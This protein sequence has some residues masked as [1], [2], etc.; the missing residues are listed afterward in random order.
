MQETIQNTG[1]DVEIHT[2]ES[3]EEGIK[4]SHGLK[5]NDVVVLDTLLSGI[6]GFEACKRIKAINE[7]IKVI[8]C[9]G[10]VDAVDATR[11]RAAGADDYCVKTENYGLLI[12]AVKQLT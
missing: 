9:T 5:P 1:W 10:V 4:K 3:G 12:A 2:A 8:I 6:G 7:N 11:A